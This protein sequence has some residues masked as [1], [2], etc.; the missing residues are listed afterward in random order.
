LI[1]QTEKSKDKKSA[2]RESS[3]P[4]INSRNSITPNAL[5]NISLDLRRLLNFFLK[6][7]EVLKSKNKPLETISRT[8]TDSRSWFLEENSQ[9]QSELN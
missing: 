2:S 4:N 9:R 3:Q 1:L 7:E 8:L 5:R 6:L